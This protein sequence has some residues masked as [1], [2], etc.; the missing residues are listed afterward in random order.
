MEAVEIDMRFGSL[1][2][3]GM[4]HECSYQIMSLDIEAFLTRG[5]KYTLKCGV[6]VRRIDVSDL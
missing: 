4:I 3:V 1:E 2:E 6:I 5:R